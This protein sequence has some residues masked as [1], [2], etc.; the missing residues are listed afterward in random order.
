MRCRKCGMEK[1][2]DD[3]PRNKNSRTGKH[4]YCKPCHNAQ[5]R[6][7]VKRNYGGYRHYRLKHKY[8]IGAADVDRMIAEQG[9]KCP[10]CRKRAA[11][12]VD[13]DHATGKV[14]AIVCE[15]CNGG[16]GQF[17]DNPETIR[18][19]IA[20]IRLHQDEGKSS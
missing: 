1:S 3:F 14:R 13:H 17:K 4:S 6:E 15:M 8:G 18:R 5:V 7:S 9:G 16:L 19:A 2:P 10:I 11:V 12:H 20:Y